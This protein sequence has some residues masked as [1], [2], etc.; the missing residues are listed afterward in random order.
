MLGKSILVYLYTWK[1]LDTF[2]MIHLQFHLHFLYGGL[3]PKCP[4]YMPI[5][6]GPQFKLFLAIVVLRTSYTAGISVELAQRKIR[7]LDSDLD[8]VDA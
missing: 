3:R 1:S 4:C 7:R 2:P 8:V 6:I 5:I